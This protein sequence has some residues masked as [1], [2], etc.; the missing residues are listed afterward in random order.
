M[1]QWVTVW[2]AAQLVGVP[3]GVLQQRVRSGE[4]ELAD[5]LVST[6]ALIKLYPQTQLESSGMFE[7]VVQIRD[8][9]FGRRVRERTA[10]LEGL[11]LQ[12]QEKSRA[13]EASS[14]TDALTEIIRTHG[15]MSADAARDHKRELVAAKRYVRDVY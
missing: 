8:E 10:A 3:R 6:E 5:G 2:R 7:R 15:G 1:A 12:L 14:L 11:S 9:A 13:L 4:I